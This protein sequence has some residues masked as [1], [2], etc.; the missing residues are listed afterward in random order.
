MS[1]ERLD[2][3]ITRPSQKGGYRARKM[4]AREKPD[5]RVQRRRI[6]E[7]EYPA[8]LDRMAKAGITRYEA[9]L[10]LGSVA[11]YGKGSGNQ[12]EKREQQRLPVALLEIARDFDHSLLTL[13]WTEN[14]YATFLYEI[15]RAGVRSYRVDVSAR[16]ITYFGGGNSYTEVIP[17]AK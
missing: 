14:D 9:D 4:A 8:M 13:A 7:S 6:G 17:R 10:S 15:A 12:D 3:G 1:P 11:Y 2:A 16:T 5:V